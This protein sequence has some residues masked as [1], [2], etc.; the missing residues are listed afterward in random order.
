VRTKPSAI[1]SWVSPI[2]TSDHAVDENVQPL[3][4]D[5]AR[6]KIDD[7]LPEENRLNFRPVVQIDPAFAKLMGGIHH[8]AS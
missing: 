1:A 7:W 3:A 2:R 6:D 5:C 4:F 8:I